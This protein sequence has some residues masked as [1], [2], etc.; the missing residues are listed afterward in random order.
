VTWELKTHPLIGNGK[1]ESNAIMEY[2]TPS[3]MTNGSRAGNDELCGSV[4][5]VIMQQ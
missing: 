5:I 1:I 4:L 3:N 2:I